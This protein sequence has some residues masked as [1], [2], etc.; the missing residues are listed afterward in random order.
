MVGSGNSKKS[1]SGKRKKRRFTQEIIWGWE[2]KSNKSLS[3]KV[4]KHQGQET[5]E[6]G[7]TE[8]DST[9]LKGEGATI[10]DFPVGEDRIDWIA[11][12]RGGG[13]RGGGDTPKSTNGKDT[14]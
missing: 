13:F 3:A 5:W 2:K 4:W 1:T 7:C 9:N 12:K 11:T 6:R 10:C 8:R 14:H